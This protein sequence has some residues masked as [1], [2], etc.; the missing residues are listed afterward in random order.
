MKSA[1]PGLEIL[2]SIGGWTASPNF[3]AMASQVSARQNFAATAVTLMTSWGMDGLD[4]DWEWPHS[5][6]EA[7]AMLELIEAMRT[8]LDT[9]ATT[10]PTAGSDNKF[11]LSI[12]LPVAEVN[13]QFMDLVTMDTIVDQFNVQAYDFAGSFSEPQVSGHAANLQSSTN[14]PAATPF[15]TDT[16]ITYFLA[17]ITPSKITLGMPLYGRSF[18]NTDG[19]GQ[20]FNGVGPGERTEEPGIWDYKALPKPG[21]TVHYDDQAVAAYSYDSAAKELI[22]YDTPQS[23]QAKVRY[24]KSR[25]LGGAMFWEASGDKTGDESLVVTAWNELGM[26]TLEKS[27]NMSYPRIYPRL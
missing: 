23:V 12:S 25:G 16:A 24:L 6:E 15:N 3:P 19:L 18:T 4:L 21:A 26:G 9:R 11:T 8:E 20:P 10:Y 1:N 22:S 27:R 13:Y 7:A 2:L 5:A 14:T 17:H